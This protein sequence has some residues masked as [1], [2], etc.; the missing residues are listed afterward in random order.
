MYIVSFI[1]NL[2]KYF[3]HNLVNSNAIILLLLQSEMICAQ[4]YQKLF[5][6]L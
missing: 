3:Q 1:K 6:T 5:I 4:T 2:A